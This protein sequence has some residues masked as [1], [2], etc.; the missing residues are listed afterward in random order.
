[1]TSIFDDLLA[2]FPGYSYS[3]YSEVWH[4]R[5]KDNTK[6]NYYV[7]LP[8][9]NKDNTDVQVDKKKRV[10]NIN[11]NDPSI[12]IV[13]SYSK[14]ITLPHDVDETSVKAKAVDGILTVTFD[15]KKKY[16]GDGIEKIV[17]E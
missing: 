13:E 1:M 7:L 3:K 12:K 9:C 5:S 15:I 16:Q 10:L 8:G 6:K 2:N 4:D 14:S 11:F 17:I